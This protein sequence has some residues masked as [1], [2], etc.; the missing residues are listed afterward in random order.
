MSRR[1]RERAAAARAGPGG[2]ALPLPQLAEAQTEESTSLYSEAYLEELRNSTPSAPIQVAAAD[3]DYGA[4]KEDL[5]SP[6]MTFADPNDPLGTVSKF[7]T[8]AAA[9]AAAAKPTMNST[10]IP[11]PALIKVLKARRAARAANADKPNAEDFVSL[12]PDNSGA[13]DTDLRRNKKKKPTRLVRRE[14]LDEDDDPEL[15]SFIHDPS[16]ATS[17][18]HPTRLVL[19]SALSSRKGA[20]TAERYLRRGQIQEAL[21]L[22]TSTDS[23]VSTPPSGDSE[24]DAGPNHRNWHSR[25]LYIATGGKETADS[26]TSS[27]DARL[28]Y[29]PPN[30]PHVPDLADCIQR[31]QATLAEMVRIR[32]DTVRKVEEVR[33]ERG[34]VEKRKKEVQEELDKLGRECE[35]LGLGDTHELAEGAARANSEGLSTPSLANMG[36]GLETFGGL[37][38]HPGSLSNDG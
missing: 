2:R 33:A 34:E 19:T 28:R 6:V 26:P 25:Q 5:D 37:G 30:I 7:G 14:I 10:S 13:S 15:A 32:D 31:L 27:L 8:T 21:A 36:R 12:S 18:A 29:Q 4:S 17:T 35:R 22:S 1:A 3:E 24:S 38:T 23:A 9:V 20:E 11:D 16:V